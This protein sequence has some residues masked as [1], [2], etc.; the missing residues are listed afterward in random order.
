[1]GA[2]EITHNIGV[3]NKQRGEGIGS[4]PRF[5]LI[6]QDQDSVDYS[7]TIE[8]LERDDGDAATRRE[9]DGS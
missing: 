2:R 6:R 4:S 1:M 8:R 9:T 5:R 7:F 3:A